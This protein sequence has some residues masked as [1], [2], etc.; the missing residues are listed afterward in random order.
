MSTALA[1]LDKK[2]IADAVQPVTTEEEAA[3]LLKEAGLSQAVNALKWNKMRQAGLFFAQD[4]HGAIILDFVRDRQALN[5]VRDSLVKK[6]R[7]CKDEMKVPIA[8]AIADIAKTHVKMA[9]TELLAQEV[10]G[11]R[12]T[13]LIGEARDPAGRRESQDAQPKQT[14]VNILIKGVDAKVEGMTTEV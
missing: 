2:V 9:E 12:S 13:K 4:Y 1:N 7:C 10:T 6:F 14:S 5:E 11:R 8:R 3:I